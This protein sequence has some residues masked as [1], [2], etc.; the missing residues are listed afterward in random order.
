MRQG[1]EHGG[2]LVT[3]GQ[4]LGGS[5]STAVR[6]ALAA[7]PAVLGFQLDRIDWLAVE[8]G[9]DMPQSTLPRC[10]VRG[11]MP[12]KTGFQWNLIRIRTRPKT[13]N[14]WPLAGARNRPQLMSWR[15]LGPLSTTLAPATVS[16]SAPPP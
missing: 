10:R 7:L 5:A 8:V 9:D 13:K 2:G 4:A 11:A 14:S 15:R 12:A 16:D 3:G 6:G 1:S